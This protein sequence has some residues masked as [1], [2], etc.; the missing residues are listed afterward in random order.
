MGRDLSGS[1]SE[2][3][4]VPGAPDQLL[5]QGGA[6]L[7]SPNP[8]NVY[9]IFVGSGWSPAQESLI[10]TFFA[11]FSN[12]PRY[13]ILS[14]YHSTATPIS[15]AV[16]Y[17]GSASIGDSM[18]T[19]ITL[20]QMSQIVANTISSGLLPR[21]PQA[22]YFLLGD[23]KV[24]SPGF[25][26]EYCG[27]HASMGMARDPN[28]YKFA[29]I[30]NAASQCPSACITQPAIS[31]NGDPGVDAMI[32]VVSHELAESVSDP[33]LNGYVTP[34]SGT[35][36]ETGDFCNF[37]FGTTYQTPS[38]A[39]ANLHVNGRDY[40]VQLLWDRDRKACAESLTSPSLSAS[41]SVTPTSV[42]TNTPI[43]VSGVSGISLSAMPILVVTAVGYWA[44]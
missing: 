13:S 39:Q 31:P 29:F 38:G 16:V 22:V 19:N 32:N 15:N 7:G 9:G 12:S 8:P 6:V 17:G 11:D 37:I 41:A 1:L 25:C 34:F 24:T 3:P 10:K 27:F 33:T 21:D 35:Y 23:R 42:T 28:S 36:W 26:T 14:S 18:G 5:F 40:L 44:F 4:P 43:P 2:V 20:S 30:G